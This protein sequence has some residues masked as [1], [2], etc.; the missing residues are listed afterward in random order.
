MKQQFRITLFDG[1]NSLCETVALLAAKSNGAVNAFSLLDLQTVAKGKLIEF[2]SLYENTQV[3]IIGEH[4]LHI[5]RKVDKE[6]K[7]V[8]R[9]ELVTVE[10]LVE[11]EEE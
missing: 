3:E 9:I 5:D 4:T 8:C 2:P 7:T 11:A 1:S 6:Y 10:E